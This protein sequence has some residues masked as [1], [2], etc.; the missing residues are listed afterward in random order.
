[1]TLQNALSCTSEENVNLLVFR[2]DKIFMPY[3]L[4]Q[5]HGQRKQ[6]LIQPKSPSYSFLHSV[7]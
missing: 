2:D 6:E 3:P 4:S 5:C 1:M 7:N